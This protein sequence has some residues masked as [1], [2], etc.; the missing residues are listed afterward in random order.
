L[1][2]LFVTKRPDLTQILYEQSIDPNEIATIIRGQHTTPLYNGLIHSSLDMDRMDYLIRDAIGTGV[3]FGR[4]DIDYLLDHLDADSEGRL[5]LEP[6][7]VTA[8]E[9]FMLARYLMSKVVYFHKT[10]FAFEALLRQ[11]LFLLRKENSLW[12]DGDTVKE[13]AINDFH[14]S[15]FHDAYIDGLIDEAAGRYDTLGVLCKSLRLRRPPELLVEYRNLE[16][17]DGKR[18]EE[19]I[20]FQTRRKD[21]LKPLAEKHGIPQECFLWEDPKDLSLEKVGPFV[22][23][24]GQ[25]QPE[26]KEELLLVIET[27]GT[28]HPLIEDSNSLIHHLSQLRLRTTRLYLVESDEANINAVRDEVQE[29]SRP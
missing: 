12:R 5:G 22:G 9:H 20:R 2:Q 29:W 1:G 14:F 25:L 3:P 24:S 6:K 16:R 18:S 23:I 4:I 10:V 8:A 7:A 27:N 19:A 28:S 11:I 26:E 17:V 21:K 15:R 13:F